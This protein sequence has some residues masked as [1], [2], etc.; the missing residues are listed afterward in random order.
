MKLFDQIRRLSKGSSGGKQ[1]PAASSQKTLQQQTNAGVPRQELGPQ[2]DFKINLEKNS[3][4]RI[5]SLTGGGGGPEGLGVVVIYPEKR[6]ML[7]RAMKDEGLI[8]A[9]NRAA[10]TEVQVRPGDMIVAINSVFGNTDDMAK[11]FVGQNSLTLNIKR[12]AANLEPAPA[13]MASYEPAAEP[14]AIQAFE[15]RFDVERRLARDLIAYTR[16][17]FQMFF[18]AAAEEEWRLAE[19]RLAQGPAAQQSLGLPTAGIAENSSWESFYD[20]KAGK[21][22]WQQPNEIVMVPREE[23]DKDDHVTCKA[24]CGW[25]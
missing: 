11:E 22:S 19:E 15:K 6:V 12:G 24:V 8:P 17:E 18:G 21:S 23:N 16:Q 2:G 13:P 20:P 9:W 14:M 25:W 4:G 7:V 1:E 3:H 5:S 10:E